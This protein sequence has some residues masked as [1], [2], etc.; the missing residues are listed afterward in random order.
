MYG[1]EDNI[2]E[3]DDL[4]KQLYGNGKGR[5]DHVRVELLLKN[6][7]DKVDKALSDATGAVHA[8]GYINH[9]RAVA[10]CP[11]CNGGE[12]VNPSK[13]DKEGFYCLAC[14][15]YQNGG[16]PVPIDWNWNYNQMA[17]QLKKRPN[18]LTRN[19][20]PWETVQ[21]IQNENDRMGVH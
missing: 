13:S 5:K 17:A 10:K 11:F 9:S 20:W 1:W 21:S 15:N 12:A 3:A 14:G 4:A 6:H 18:P 19:A 7:A 8:V 16:Y 2:S